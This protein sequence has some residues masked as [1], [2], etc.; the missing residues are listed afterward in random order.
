[1]APEDTMILLRPFGTI[2]WLEFPVTVIT[3][4]FELRIEVDRTLT[5]YFYYQTIFEFGY[6]CYP[7]I[8]A[9]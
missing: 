9:R 6:R 4:I 8:N 3:I 1:M 2:K 5:D 7:S